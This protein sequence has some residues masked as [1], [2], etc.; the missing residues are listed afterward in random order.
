[1]PVEWS[2]RSPAAWQAAAFAAGPTGAGERERAEAG[3]RAAYTAADLPRPERIV[4]VSSPAAGA[5]AAALIAGHATALRSDSAR[6]YVAQVKPL[7]DGTD[8]GAS[9]RESV[10]TRPWERARAAASTRLGPREWPRAW[11]RTGGRFWSQVDDL[12]LRIRGAIGELTVDDN[13]PLL[14]GTTLDAIL[15]QH[16]APWLCLLDSLGLLEGSE[17]PAPALAALAEVA[18]VTGW[19]W[20]YERVAVVCA[21][22]LELHRDEPGRLHRG[23]G[24]AL[25]Y[26]DGFALHAWRGMPVRPG[27]IDS[28]TDLSV[29]RIHA[30][31]NV[32]Q[33]RVMLEIFGYDRYLGETGAAPVHKDETG[34]LWRIDLRDDEPITMVEVVNSTPE[35]DGTH[36]TYYLR[37]PP[38]TRTAREGVAWTFGVDESDYRPERET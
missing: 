3:I 22:P 12:V 7:L 11:A 14:R 29:G 4:W 31:T 24:P 10:R 23:D 36:R 13:A 8:P 26:A 27:F 32:E 17:N 21:R 34:V 38:R 1:M 9:V 37:V 5:V 15:G 25:A 6:A 16:D 30:E 2:A 33:R 20:P 28:L 19:W 18:S 35:P